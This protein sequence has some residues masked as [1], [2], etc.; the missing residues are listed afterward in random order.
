M[1]ADVSPQSVCEIVT[2]L[3]GVTSRNVTFILASNTLYYLFKRT[4]PCSVSWVTLIRSCLFL[5]RFLDVL[6]GIRDSSV[7]RV[8]RLRAGRPW[9]RGSIPGENTIFF[10][11]RKDPPSLLF[12][13][14]SGALSP[15]LLALW[16]MLATLHIALG[17]RTGRPL[18]SL[19]HI[20]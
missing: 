6:L 1:Q 11:L 18:P 8:T 15:G 9:D 20:P 13:G 2:K 3:H 17:F 19:P 12:I 14:L 4:P 7:G 10:F 5:V 16:L